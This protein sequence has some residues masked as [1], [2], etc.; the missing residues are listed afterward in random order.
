MAFSKKY[1]K[2]FSEFLFFWENPEESI[3]ACIFFI[4]KSLKLYYIYFYIIFY[5]NQRCSGKKFTFFWKTTFQ[6][7]VFQKKKKWTARRTELNC[8]DFAWTELNCLPKKGQKRRFL[9]FF[10]LFWVNWW[11]NWWTSSVHWTELNWYLKSWFFWTFFFF[12]ELVHEL[13]NWTGFL[14][15]LN[16]TGKK[17]ATFQIILEKI[18][19]FCQFFAKKSELVSELVSKIELVQFS[20]PVQS[21]VQCLIELVPTLPKLNW[22]SWLNQFSSI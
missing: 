20:S 3:S 15:E 8:T 22:F 18:V 19:F 2:L 4:Q 13:V 9:A 11:V 6:I 17:K 21:P 12:I 10:G 5:Y 14:V 16:W 7:I 1:S